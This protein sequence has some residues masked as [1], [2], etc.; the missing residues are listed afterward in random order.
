MTEN[1]FWRP[2]NMSVILIRPQ[3]VFNQSDDILFLLMSY[4]EIANCRVVIHDHLNEC[5][6]CHIVRVFTITVRFHT[7]SERGISNTTPV[8]TWM[9]FDKK[10]LDQRERIDRRLQKN[11]AN[12]GYTIKIANFSH[13]LVYIDVPRVH[14]R[15]GVPPA[16]RHAL[17]DYQRRIRRQCISRP[18]LHVPAM[19]AWRTCTLNASKQGEAL[20]PLTYV[21]KR[22]HLLCHRL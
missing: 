7:S 9:V 10:M 4:D 12:S 20:I 17:N 2:R 21:E 14:Q 6:Q 13:F 5:H 3:N 18:S 22:S 8:S 19:S 1:S 11:V 16:I 15:A